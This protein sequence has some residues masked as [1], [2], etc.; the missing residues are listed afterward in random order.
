M[1]SQVFDKKTSNV[2]LLNPGNLQIVN[3][4]FKNGSNAVVGVFLKRLP[5]I[6][7]CHES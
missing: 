5:N 6:F 1:N 2:R 4:W 3:D 7:R